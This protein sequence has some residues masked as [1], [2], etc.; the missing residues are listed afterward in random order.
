LPCNN[1][2]CLKCIESFKQILNG[3]AVNCKCKQKIHYINKIEDK[4]EGWYGTNIRFCQFAYKYDKVFKNKF[5]Q[6]LFQKIGYIVSS[7]HAIFYNDI[8]FYIEI[9]EFIFEFKNDNKNYHL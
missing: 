3:Y 5:L 8:I 7:T 2:A 4:W 9:L 6:L 1:Q